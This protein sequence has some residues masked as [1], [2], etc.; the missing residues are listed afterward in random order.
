MLAEFSQLKDLECYVKF[1]G[2]RPCTKLQMTFQEPSH[3]G[4][5]AFLLKPE[6]KREYPAYELP[7]EEE[8][9]KEEKEY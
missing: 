3:P 8:V 1:P 7:I 4:V 9:P 6:K 2:D 5:P